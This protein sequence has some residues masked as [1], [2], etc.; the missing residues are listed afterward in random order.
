[1]FL[2]F[3]HSK[4]HNNTNSFET[5]RFCWNANGKAKESKTIKEYANFVNYS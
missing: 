2:G 5:E 1:M 4:T 3:Q